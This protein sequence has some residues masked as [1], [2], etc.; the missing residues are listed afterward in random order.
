MNGSNEKISVSSYRCMILP[1][2]RVLLFSLADRLIYNS[3]FIRRYRVIYTTAGKKEE[4]TS[5]SSPSFTNNLRNLLAF[6]L[7][8]FHH[9][10]FKYRYS[11]SRI[12]QIVIRFCKSHFIRFHSF[13]IINDALLFCIHIPVMLFTI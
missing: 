4:A 2:Y 8:R 11:R 1:P 7:S 9:P 3:C 10:V 6:L 5:A 13:K 12:E